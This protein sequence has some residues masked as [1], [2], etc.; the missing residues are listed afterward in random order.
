M[1][2]HWDSEFRDWIFK[3]RLYVFLSIVGKCYQTT[4]F[5]PEFFTFKLTLVAVKFWHLQERDNFKSQFNVDGSEN[6]HMCIFL[7]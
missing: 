2:S 6:I 3:L 5:H 4:K 1:H 7:S